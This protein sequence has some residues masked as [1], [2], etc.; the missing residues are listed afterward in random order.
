MSEILDACRGLP[1]SEFADGAVLLREG[2]RSGRLYVLMTGEVVISKGPVEVARTAVP[3]ALFGEMGALLGT[4]HS[5]SVTAAG[6][7]RAW[8]IDDVRGFLAAHPEVA[9][10]A[11]TLLAR[12]LHNATLYVADLKEQNRAKG[13][14]LG[15]LS[16]MLNMLLQRDDAEDSGEPEEVSAA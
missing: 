7:V 12:R 16:D 9:L 5:A 15:A 14:E 4:A 6:P 10:H 8:R 11:A 2:M 1:V 3:G 13:A